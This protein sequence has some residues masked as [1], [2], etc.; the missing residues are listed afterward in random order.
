[1]KSNLIIASA[2]AANALDTTD[3]SREG[4]SRA[5]RKALE[6]EERKSQRE[7]VTAITPLTLPQY[8]VPLVA[9]VI[10]RTVGPDIAA[11]TTGMG[12]LAMEITAV[13]ELLGEKGIMTQDE[14][15]AKRITIEEKV[16]Q[17]REAATAAQKQQEEAPAVNDQSPAFQESTQNANGA[18]VRRLDEGRSP[19]VIARR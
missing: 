6:K 2:E 12:D 3:T 18:P 16:Q 14:V 4:L 19:L 1:M 10:T 9:K 17:L 11:L 13:I 8:A 5:A 7:M 15:D